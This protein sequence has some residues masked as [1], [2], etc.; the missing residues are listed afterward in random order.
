[1]LPYIFLVLFC[2]FAV[3]TFAKSEKVQSVLDDKLL[4]VKFDEKQPVTF[5]GKKSVNGGNGVGGGMMYPADTA[6]LFLVSILTHA[7][8]SGSV[9]KSR[10]TKEQELANKVLDP[11]ASYIAN[12]NADYLF[13]PNDLKNFEQSGMSF[14][15]GVEEG[16]KSRWHLKTVPVFAMTQNQNSLIVYNKMTFIDQSLIDTKKKINKKPKR[17]K[18][19]AVDPNEK[20]VVIVSDPISAESAADF[21]IRDNAKAFQDTVKN[22]YLE[23]F[24]LG[25]SR[26]FG[27]LDAA[28]EKQVTVKYLEDG[29]KKIE[30]GYVI[31]QTCKRTVFESLAKEIK[32]VPNLDYTSC[33]ES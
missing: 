25:V 20:L 4:V 30:R 12:V 17:A 5:V 23:S 11:Y 6:G 15:K 9:E 1:M 2:V 33:S 21:W 31:S 22:L 27:N 26:Q 24:K 14:L 28:Q 13:N 10:L 8:V 7:A 19:G 18:R 29:V 32:S 3:D 16:D